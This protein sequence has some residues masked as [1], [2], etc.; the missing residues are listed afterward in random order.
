[1]GTKVVSPFAACQ[2][3]RCCGAR[4]RHRQALQRR[5]PRCSTEAHKRY[6]MWVRSQRC[7]A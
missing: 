5:R 3:G 4:A 2:E 1:M 7:W 6:M